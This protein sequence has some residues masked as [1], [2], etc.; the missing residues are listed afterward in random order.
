M[1]NIYATDAPQRMGPLI[2]IPGL[3]ADFGVPLEKVLAGLP[4]GPEIFADPERRIPYALAAELLQ[5]CARLSNCEHFGLIL[6]SRHDHRS[7]GAP[8]LWMQNAPD[9]ETALAG[10]VALQRGNS[11]GASV[12][13]H[14]YG[15]TVV[16]GYGI[17]ERGAVAYEQAYA[18]IAAL[19]F[20]MVQ[21]LTGGVAQ[22]AEVLFSFRR[23]SESKSYSELFGVPIRFDQPETGLVLPMSALSAPIPGARPEEMKRLKRL[24]ASMAPASHRVWTDRVRHALRPLLLRNEPTSASAA[25]HLSVNVRTLSR[26]LAS[27]GTSFQEILDDVRYAMARELLAVTDMPIGDIA[28]ALCYSAHGPFIDAF[29][30]WSGAAPSMWR[31]AI[32]DA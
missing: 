1:K 10:F 24:A 8:G 19:I 31:H 21:A 27:E 3:L 5:D 6:G 18:L 26:R 11:R 20:N 14:R 7:L 30:R 12:Y 29:R 32:R 28:A 22:I 25:A 17:Y 16:F 13:L 9:L 2:G 4:L 23:P 15:D